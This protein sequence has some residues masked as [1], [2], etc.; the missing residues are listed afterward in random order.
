M[1]DHMDLSLKRKI[2][3][4]STFKSWVKPMPLTGQMRPSLSKVWYPSCGLLGRS[5]DSS[6][7]CVNNG[8]RLVSLGHL[9]LL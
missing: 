8:L 1:L 2:S 6:L 3:L 7:A 9:W 5:W 4:Q